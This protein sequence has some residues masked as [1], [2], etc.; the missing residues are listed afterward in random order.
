MR[1]GINRWAGT[2]FLYCFGKKGIM[3]KGIIRAE[4][5][6]GRLLLGYVHGMEEMHVSV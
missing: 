5:R 3:S 1:E 6:I 4:V 2:L